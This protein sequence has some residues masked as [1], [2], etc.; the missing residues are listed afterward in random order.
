M[1]D[2]EDPPTALTRSVQGANPSNG[3]TVANVVLAPNG[4]VNADIAATWLA[5][6][7]SFAL[8]VTDSGSAF[9][10]GTL[11]VTVT[12]EIAP[13]AATV[14]VGR[15]SLWPANNDLVDV[16]LSGNSTDHCDPS[17]ELRV[18]VYSNESDGAGGAHSPDAK[19]V[20]NALM[21]RAERLGGGDGRVYLIVATATDTAGNRGVAAT[22]V[23]VPKAN[24]AKW[25]TQVA[26]MAQE[27]R[28]HALANDGAPPPGYVVVGDG[29]VLGPKQ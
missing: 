2:A 29:P 7:A 4:D 6:N 16:G 8:R 21:L 23:V 17:P 3:V 15:T 28:A 1:D 11:D 5:T 13:P 20:G 22:T 24:A 10:E 27:A 19:A 18:D 9:A 12:P 14:S 25:Q 26:V